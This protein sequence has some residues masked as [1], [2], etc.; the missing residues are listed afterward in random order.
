MQRP[1]VLPSRWL[2]THYDIS[3]TSRLSETLLQLADRITS[4]RPDC[5]GGCAMGLSQ[6]TAIASR[7]IE[8]DHRVTQHTIGKQTNIA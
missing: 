3:A 8:P 2:Q 5:G 7:S 4:L 1:L 6:Q